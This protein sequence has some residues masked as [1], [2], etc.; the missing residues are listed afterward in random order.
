MSL[1]LAF[2]SCY[3]TKAN[4][5]EYNA[6]IQIKFFFKN[7]MEKFGLTSKIPLHLI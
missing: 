2:K 6:S 1:F 4:F 3:Q 7:S 5:T